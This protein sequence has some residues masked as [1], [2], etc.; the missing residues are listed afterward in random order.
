MPLLFLLLDVSHSARPTPN[1]EYWDKLI[2]DLGGYQLTLGKGS[3]SKYGY[4]EN[5]DNV[6]KRAFDK[7]KSMRKKAY[8]YLL[9]YILDEDP[10]RMKTAIVVLSMLTGHAPRIP[11][12]SQKEAAYR[13][14]LGYLGLFEDQIPR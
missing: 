10:Q 3:E 14:W 5:E 6:G 13:E 11:K 4:E 2:V 1:D 7:V 12:P 8:P 9:K